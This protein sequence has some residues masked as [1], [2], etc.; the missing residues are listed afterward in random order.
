MPERRRAQCPQGQDEINSRRRTAE[1]SGKHD[2]PSPIENKET[3]WV[4]KI[5][6]CEVSVTGGW[7]LGR[8]GEHNSW[9]WSASASVEKIA[10]VSVAG[11]GA[12][13][14]GFTLLLKGVWAGCGAR[15]R[16]WHVPIGIPSEGSVD[17]AP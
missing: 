4:G 11:G 12:R 5:R 17:I 15:V 16:G 1:T 14:R 10:S 13:T 6:E 9:A 2:T 7:I 8:N 3:V